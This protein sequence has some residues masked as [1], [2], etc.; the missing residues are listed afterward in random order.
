M[1]LNSFKWIS[2]KS[3]EIDGTPPS[4]SFLNFLGCL[5]YFTEGGREREREEVLELQTNLFSFISI[6]TKIFRDKWI[7]TIVQIFKIHL[8]LQETYKG[9]ISY[10]MKLRTKKQKMYIIVWEWER[11]MVAEQRPGNGILEKGQLFISKYS[12]EQLSTFK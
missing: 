7:L 8:D 6:D 5:S 10:N 3:F 11:L 2:S 4:F 1:G 12:L 9:I